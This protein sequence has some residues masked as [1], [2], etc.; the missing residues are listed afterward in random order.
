MRLVD[1]LEGMEKDTK[2]PIKSLKTDGG[3]SQSDILLQC[4]ADFAN[5]D[6]LRASEAD[7]TATG[8][9]F[10]AGL[11]ANFWKDQEELIHIY[12][13][14][15]PDTFKPKLSQENRAIKRKKWI[16]ALNAIL[17]IK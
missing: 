12:F 15:N 17:R 1:I 16:T 7:M 5:L 13:N 3:V 11:G 6:V 9:A 4:I 14:T 2:I 10:L 8:I